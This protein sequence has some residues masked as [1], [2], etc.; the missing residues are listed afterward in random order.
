MAFKSKHA[1]MQGG[2]SLSFAGKALAYMPV[3]VAAISMLIA[4]YYLDKSYQYS[5]GIDLRVQAA[6]AVSIR[7][8]NLQRRLDYEIS[9]AAAVRDEIAHRPDLDT[10]TFTTITDAL[11]KQN[12]DILQITAIRNTQDFFGVKRDGI[13]FASP[14]VQI[15]PNVN[16]AAEEDVNLGNQPKISDV[17]MIDPAHYG[18]YVSIPAYT[19]VNDTVSRWGFV[20]VVFDVRKLL[21]KAGIS[22]YGSGDFHY[23]IESDTA[24]RGAF[25]PFFRVDQIDTV[26]RL[27]PATASIEALGN[28]WRLA[29][30]PVGGWERVPAKVWLLRAGIAIFGVLVLIPFFL[31]ARLRLERNSSMAVLGDRERELEVLSRRFDFAL[32]SYRCGVWEAATNIEET[33]WDDRTLALHGIEYR[34]N[35]ITRRNWLNLVHPDD[36]TRAHETLLKAT[37]TRG[38]FTLQCRIVRPE[39][40]VRHIKYVAQFHADQQGRQRLYGIALDVTDDVALTQALIG[41]NAEAEKKNHE[42]ETVLADLSH[43]ENRLKETS[44]RLSLAL[45]VYGCGVWDADLET[46]VTIWDERMHALFGLAYTDGITDA[47]AWE[48]CVHPDDLQH[49]L[50][51]T[52]AAINDSVPYSCTYR[53]MTP[54]GA[55]RHIH[56][57]GQ[58][59]IT[60]TGGRKFIGI[61]LDVTEQA[62]KNEALL[63]AKND[64]EARRAELESAHMSI[65]HNATH[66]PL[67]GL[68]NRRALDEELERL[69]TKPRPAAERITLLHLD[70]DRF[71][72]INDTLGHAAGDAMLKHAARVLQANTRDRD[73]VARIGGDEFVIVFK[74]AA[75]NTEIGAIANRIIEA[76][77]QPVYFQGHE[78]RFGVSIGI[79]RESAQ[80]NSIR[81]LLV[82]ADIALYRAKAHGR[83]R[84]EFFTASLQGEI[85][86]TKKLADDI[87]RGIENNEFVAW[88]QPQVSAETCKLSGAEAL[89]RW[90]HPENGLLTPDKFLRVAE[91][92]NAVST[93]DRI[94]LESAMR[95]R[96]VWLAGGLE[97]P[98]ISVNVSARRLGDDQLVK[99]IKDLAIVPGQIAFELV[100][101]IYLDDDDSVIVRN[102]KRLK[103]LGIDIEIDDFGTGH[104]SIV[105]L[106]KLE[107]KRLKID[108]QLVMPMLTSQREH[109]LVRSILEIGT[110]LD[111]ETVAEGVETMA[112]AARLK[113][114]GCTSLQGY[115]FARP[116]A[117]SDVLAKFGPQ[118]LQTDAGSLKRA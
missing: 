72:Q 23:V 80:R 14:P 100:E 24:P 45:G 18:V 32:D 103:A 37:E 101:S 87:L 95:D 8:D 52:K 97:M 55:L 79:A 49:A 81:K 66:D 57:V 31:S 96:L 10:D 46:G 112:H 76:M 5:N 43:S 25:K 111:I 60:A 89:V 4:G 59:R 15:K 12:E 118:R 40:D 83:N 39:G 42:L 71:K 2:P 1:P 11:L 3:A 78:C 7:A 67:T 115:A 47:H 20:S 116:M 30:I 110:S 21:A 44:Q 93:L 35:W 90:N 94:V 113:E 70:L 85:R 53:I 68:A 106:L 117:A 73:L 88:Y 38:Q 28:R 92:I 54:D 82:N 63:T 105:S 26:M 61:A 62:Q 108:R 17:F 91:E 58:T 19:R 27:N 6:D 9:A 33:Y 36:R 84:Y 13:P 74:H 64:A 51:A 77:N 29:A 109:S 16:G 50:A 104:T 86:R 102:I 56:A 107:P 69:A 75:D 34:H 98:K 65:Q 41:A 48:S 114:L 99:S 22:Y